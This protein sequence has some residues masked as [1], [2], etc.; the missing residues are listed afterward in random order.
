MRH[1]VLNL[2]P[3]GY[4]AR[5]NAMPLTSLQ[6]SPDF[7]KV[8][9]A[10][11]GYAVQVEDPEQL[12]R[13]WPP[14]IAHSSESHT[15]ACRGEDQIGHSACPGIRCRRPPGAACNI[16]PSLALIQVRVARVHGLV[17]RAGEEGGVVRRDNVEWCRAGPQAAARCFFR[18]FARGVSCLSL[19]FALSAT[20]PSDMAEQV[21]LHGER[22]ASDAASSC[23]RSIL[24]MILALN[25]SVSLRSFSRKPRACFG[26]IDALDPP[27]DGIRLA[28]HEARGLQAVD[29]GSNRNLADV[30]FVGELGLRQAVLARDERQHPPLRAG[31][32]ERRQGTIGTSSSGVATRRE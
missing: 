7:T 8:A 16:S 25:L 14:H 17:V 15:G 24:L 1:L 3:D 31:N 30:E 22:S 12:P 19:S 18:P 2:Y 28:D 9:Q 26:D 5:A 23:L 32:S 29:Q 11:R 4:A 6:P 13:R 21:V 27:V 10:S 20:V